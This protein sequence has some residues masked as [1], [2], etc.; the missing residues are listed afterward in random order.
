MK[1]KEKWKALTIRMPDELRKL[2]RKKA[3][4]K[5]TNVAEL[6]RL[7]LTKETKC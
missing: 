4:E 6:I 7:I 3:R 5:N 1:Y 2:I